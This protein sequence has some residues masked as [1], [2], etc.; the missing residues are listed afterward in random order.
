[1]SL[2]S[3][4]KRCQWAATEEIKKLDQIE[5]CPQAIDLTQSIAKR[6]SSD[7]GG[8]LIVDYGLDG[9]VSDSLQV[10]TLPLLMME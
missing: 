6:I 1:M 3:L 7:G 2:F 10:G 8:A 5:V 4:V 9:V